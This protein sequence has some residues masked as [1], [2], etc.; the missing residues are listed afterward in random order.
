[1]FGKLSIIFF[2]KVWD[3]DGVSTFQLSEELLQTLRKMNDR[4]MKPSICKQKVIVIQRFMSLPSRVFRDLCKGAN[5]FG[6]VYHSLSSG[7]KK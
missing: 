4:H 6:L 2:W 7:K 5:L 3:G 1:M